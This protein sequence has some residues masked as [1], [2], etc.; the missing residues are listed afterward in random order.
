M[1]KAE[2]IFQVAFNPMGMRTKRSI[3]YMEGAMA[4]LLNAESANSVTFKK[5]RCPYEEGTA[6][7]DAWFAGCDEGRRLWRINGGLYENL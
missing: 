4:S 5:R 7:F 6:A 1:S 2:L 3:E